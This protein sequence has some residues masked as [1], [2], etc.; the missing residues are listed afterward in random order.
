MKGKIGKVLKKSLYRSIKALKRSSRDGK[1]PKV[2]AV[3]KVKR[4]YGGGYRGKYGNGRIQGQTT[5]K[6]H[7]QRRRVTAGIA[8]AAGVAGAAKVGSTYGIH[9]KRKSDPGKRKTGRK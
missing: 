9:K 2:T 5:T 3:E 1:R 8:A 4:Y 7:F 6:K